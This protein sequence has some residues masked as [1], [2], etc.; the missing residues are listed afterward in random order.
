MPAHEN[1]NELYFQ[2]D[3]YIAN[4]IALSIMDRQELVR[5]RPPDSVLLSVKNAV[6]VT[7]PKTLEELIY[8]WLLWEL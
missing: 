2:E 5:T 4:E 7:K 6:C 3:T 8:M 1:E